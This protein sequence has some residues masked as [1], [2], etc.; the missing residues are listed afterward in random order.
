MFPGFFV[1][2]FDGFPMFVGMLFFYGTM[3][4][5]VG[6]LTIGILAGVKWILDTVGNR[7]NRRS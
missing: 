2:G 5:I 3:L 1:V 7:S 6:C 4:G